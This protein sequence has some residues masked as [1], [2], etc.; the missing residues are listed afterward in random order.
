[1]PL[2]NPHQRALQRVWQRRC[3]NCLL[4]RDPSD[5][6]RRVSLSLRA[7][8]E[9]V[10]NMEA[11]LSVLCLWDDTPHPKLYLKPKRS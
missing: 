7:R 2:Y 5:E 11:I 9:G 10:V 8:K 6:H 3:L 1:M 4:S